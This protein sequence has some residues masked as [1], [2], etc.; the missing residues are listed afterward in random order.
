[1][2]NLFGDLDIA[3]AADDPFSVDEGTYEATLAEVRTDVSA[4]GNRGLIFEFTITDDSLMHG[5]TISEWKTLPADST[6]SEGQRAMSFIKMR[7]RS[8]GVPESEM[9]TLQP[10][11]LIG[12]EVILE[13]VKKGE[14]TNIKRLSLAS[15]GD[16]QYPN[17]NP[18][19]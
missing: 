4:A 7:L 15:E 17:G 12:T 6:T 8:L 9:N 14:Y 2:E 5:R 1:M 3:S 18:F 19:S 16:T 10:T 11:D 13:V